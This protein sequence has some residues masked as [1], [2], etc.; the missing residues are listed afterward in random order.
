M[1][2]LLQPNSNY[3]PVKMKKK[4]RLGNENFWVYLA[5]GFYNNF[6]LFR[7]KNEVKNEKHV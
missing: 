1:H 2:Q 6:L 7:I 3:V 5:F 4:K